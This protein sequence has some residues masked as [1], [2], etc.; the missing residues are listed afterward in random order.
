METQVE[1]CRREHRGSF[2]RAHI[3]GVTSACIAYAALILS[4]LTNFGPDRMSWEKVAVLPL[5]VYAIVF[6]FML[7]NFGRAMKRSLERDGMDRQ[8]CDSIGAQS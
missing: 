3:G 1:A 6:A 4:K 8:P 7:W 5:A 2:K